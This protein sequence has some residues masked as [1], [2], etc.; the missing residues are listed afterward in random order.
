MVSHLHNKQTE[1]L[2]FKDFSPP[3]IALRNLK[4]LLQNFRSSIYSNDFKNHFSRTRSRLAL[5]KGP[6]RVGVSLRSPEGRNRYSFRK[7]VFFSI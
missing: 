6:K 3:S 5:S 2:F 1:L 4:V 7:V